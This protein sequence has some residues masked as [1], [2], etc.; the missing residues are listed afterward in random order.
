MIRL[1]QVKIA[2]LNDNEEFH[3]RKVSKLLQ[4]NT[5]DIISLEIKKKSI[6]ARD[7]NNIFL[8]NDYYNYISFNDIY[9]VNKNRC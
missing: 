8:G 4:I 5:D 1:R 7:K 9:D 3:K 6:D 2:I